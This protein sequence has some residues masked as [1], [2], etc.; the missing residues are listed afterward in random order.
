MTLAHFLLTRFSYRDAACRAG[1]IAIMA[2]APTIDPL[3][4]RKLEKRF[5]LFELFCLPSVLAQTTKDF[6]WILL[7]DPE[8][9]PQDRDRL[10]AL[11]RGYADT[12]LVEVTRLEDL[13]YLRFLHPYVSRPGVTHIA[14]TNVDDDDLIGPELMAYTQAHLRQRE[15]Q[16]RLPSCTFVG[17]SQPS[18]WDFLPSRRAPLGYSKPWPPHDSP[19]YTGLTVCSKQ[20]EYDLSCYAFRHTI[21]KQYFDPSVTLEESAQR[22]LRAAAERA[23]EDW[24]QWRPDEHLHIVESRHP[25][26]VVVNHLENRQ[27]RRLFMGWSTRRRVTGPADFPEMPIDFDKARAVIRSFRRSP[28]ALFHHLSLRAQMLTSGKMSL[29]ARLFR[30]GYLLMGPLW[31]LRG[32]PEKKR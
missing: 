4:P 13:P 10:R 14:T 5:K 21:V 26:V 2:N 8:M 27:F 23:G 20:P 3:E 11:T 22:V 25:Q 6:T 29:R 17:C 32:M 1:Q 24:R 7:I 15:E 12:H 9:K 16:G 30:L 18:S 19:V 31:F 28:T